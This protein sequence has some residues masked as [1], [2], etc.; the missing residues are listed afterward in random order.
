MTEFRVNKEVLGAKCAKK[1]WSLGWHYVCNIAL[2]KCV[3]NVNFYCM[4]QH[5]L[6]CCIQMTLSFA[7]L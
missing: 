3:S 1:S 5:A 7:Y 2:I 6:T 4:L